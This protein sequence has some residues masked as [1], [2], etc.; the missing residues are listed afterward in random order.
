MSHAG[1]D[2][3]GTIETG[4]ALPQARSAGKGVSVDTLPA[5]PFS[6]GENDGL[7]EDEE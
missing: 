5:K 2:D 6:E 1:T 7:L 3:G 4:L